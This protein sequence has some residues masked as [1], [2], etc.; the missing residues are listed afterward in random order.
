MASRID[1]IE[2]RERLMQA[3]LEVFAAKGFRD[4]TLSDICDLAE[5]NGAAANYHFGGKEQ[6]YQAVWRRAWEEANDKLPIDGGLPE[7]A[8]AE[9]KLHALIA[10]VLSRILR[11]GS[12][13]LAG[14]LLLLAMGESEPC[15]S[16][17]RHE[18]TQPIR[19]RIRRIV[20]ELLGRRAT[21]DEV[22]HCAMSIMHQM[23]AIGFR[24]G[25]KSPLLG[26]GSF[27]DH[28]VDA[29]I[30]HVYRFSLGGISAV[31]AHIEQREAHAVLAA[32]RQ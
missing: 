19:E 6:L 21:M 1:G 5:A 32:E 2:K 14:R 25:R 17:V 11:H 26:D 16:A 4:A 15:L 7:S 13:C 8:T 29:L 18:A 20:R 24:G 23:L 28:E 27:E 31:V 22:N 10:A 12:Q 9:E 3:A 30:E